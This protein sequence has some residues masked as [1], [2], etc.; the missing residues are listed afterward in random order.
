MSEDVPA[1]LR[2]AS[3]TF[4]IGDEVLGVR[5]EA[6]A[7]FSSSGM[8]YRVFAKCRK[9]NR[10]IIAKI[11]NA[12]T[13]KIAGFRREVQFYQDIAP[14]LPV[15]V[16]RCL[17]ASYNPKNGHGVILLEDL[18][19]QHPDHGLTGPQAHQLAQY[20][21]RF[22]QHTQAIPFSSRLRWTAQT[23]ASFAVQAKRN[24][25]VVD[26]SAERLLH[27]QILPRLP[28]ACVALAAPVCMVHFDLHARNIIVASSGDIAI[29]DWQSSV[30]AH[31]A[32]DVVLGASNLAIGLDRVQWCASYLALHPLDAFWEH[33]ADAAA[34]V[35]VLA[36]D[37]LATLGPLHT[38]Q[39]DVMSFQWERIMYTTRQLLDP[40]KV[41]MG[42]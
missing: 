12:K 3:L 18:P 29:I 42:I 23:G 21:S 28:R 25:S 34:L 5:V 1:I 30:L 19:G 10:T 2:P 22:H 33:V 40:Q 37:A 13:L 11:V 35:F 32:L 17:I 41:P 27:T 26:G 8:V 38:E 36:L 24:L 14:T 4:F 31:P 16:P 15:Y 20:L 9:A 6:V 7:G 39:A